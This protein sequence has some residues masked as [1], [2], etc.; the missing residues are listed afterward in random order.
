MTARQI[1]QETGVSPATLSRVRK[2]LG[3]KKVK[4]LAQGEPVPGYER[5]KPGE[6]VHID[7]R[8]IGNSTRTGHRITGDR[9]RQSNGRGIGWE[10][11]IWPTTTAHAWPIGSPPD[12][13]LALVFAFF[14]STTLFLQGSRRERVHRVMTDN[15]TGFRYPSAAA[16]HPAHP[17]QALYARDQWQAPSASSRS[18]RANGPTL[19]CLFAGLNSAVSCSPSAGT[20]GLA[21]G[22][23][24]Q[25]HPS[26]RPRPAGGRGA[27][28]GDERTSGSGAW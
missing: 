16:Q 12:E 4:T 23:S 22:C 5:G 13:T 19:V 28:S 24:C 25:V 14:T 8:Q 17:H 7:N 10:Y 1:A 26:T 20:P 18:P 21:G 15:G 27:G 6:P 2:R 9:T 11:G 3:A